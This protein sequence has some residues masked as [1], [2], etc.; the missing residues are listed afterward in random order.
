MKVIGAPNAWQVERTCGGC[1]TRVRVD[2]TDIRLERVPRAQL[3][4]FYVFATCMV[5]GGP[6]NLGHADQLPAAVRARVE[7]GSEHEAE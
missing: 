6:M 5:C 4:G 1:R 2:V 3:K 7:K